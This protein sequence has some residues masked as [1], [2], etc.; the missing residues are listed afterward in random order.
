MPFYQPESRQTLRHE[1]KPQHRVRDRPQVCVRVVFWVCAPVSFHFPDW[2]LNSV[3]KFQ[4]ILHTVHT[5]HGGNMLFTCRTQ[6]K[7][8][9][10]PEI[11]T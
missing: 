4:M 9:G 5:G 6:V 2:F 10:D 11:N 7:L 8:C 3:F 1:P